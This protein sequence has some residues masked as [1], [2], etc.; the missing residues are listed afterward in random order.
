MVDWLEAQ[1][2]KL[3]IPVH[4]NRD[5]SKKEVQKLNPD[6]LILAAG[7]EATLPVKF[8]ETPNI[9]TQDEAILKSKPIGK[10]V[11]IWGLNAYWKGGLETVTTLGEQGYNVKALMGSN[12]IVGQLL[13]ANAGRRMYLMRYLRDK[14]I[15]VYTKAK[16]LDVNKDGVSFLDENKEEQFLEADTLVYCGSRIA[17]GNV[18]KKKFKGAAPEIV[19]IGDCK[20]PRDI[21]EAMTDA[22]KYIRNLK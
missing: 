14:K 2:K 12:A 15:P 7:S 13:M 9:I 20:R 17:N 3:N 5:L 8:K 18:L 22:Q 6:I 21:K 4:L 16:L 19:L 1:L 11:V 10:D